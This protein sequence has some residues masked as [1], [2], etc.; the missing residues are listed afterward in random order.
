M[1][2]LLE[3]PTPDLYKRAEDIGITAVMCAPWAA[4]P[5]IDE[6]ADVERY[7][8]FHRAVRRIRC[9]QMPLSPATATPSPVHLAGLRERVPGAE[10]VTGDQR[11][12]PVHR[13]VEHGVAHRFLDE[14]AHPFGD[15]E[16]RH[17]QDA[18]HDAGDVMAGGIEPVEHHDPEEPGHRADEHVVVNRH[19]LV[20]H[21]FQPALGGDHP[22]VG[23]HQH[24]PGL[25][26]DIPS[27]TKPL[28]VVGL[29]HDQVGGAGV[30]GIFR[31]QL[32]DPGTAGIPRNSA[33]SC[34]AWR[35]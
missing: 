20:A 28:D 30:G 14:V 31:S 6:G 17:H 29:K 10:Q 13:Q 33:A 7:R 9:G 35:T 32:D 5:G 34:Q 21:S 26:I 12:E 16:Q 18:D 1:V 15:H 22:G 24:H 8:A 27:G 11:A 23:R 2:A 3:R 25:V 4:E 19:R